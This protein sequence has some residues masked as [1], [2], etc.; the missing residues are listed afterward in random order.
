MK[1]PNCG[2]PAKE[3]VKVC[4]S[5]GEAYSSQDLLELCQ[6]EFMLQETESWDIPQKLRMP[7]IK[8]LETLR[9]RLQRHSPILPEEE[10]EVSASEKRAISPQ[11]A[12]SSHPTSPPKRIPFEQWLLS[13]ANIKLALWSGGLLL[14]LASIIFIGVKW[15]YI[16][17]PGK[18][19]ITL[20][21]T[22]LMYLGG[23]LL[24][25]R[26]AYR[27]GAIA[28]LGL[29][30]MFTPITFAVLQIYILGPSGLHNDVMWLIA[31][32]FCL[33]LYML[34]AYWT[35]S[36]LFTYISLAALSSAVTATL[37][38]IVAPLHAFILAYSLLALATQILAW[39]LQT[40]RLS[41]F[42]RLPLLIISQV[43][44]ALVIA[45]S[46]IGWILENGYTY[47]NM[48]SLWF[49][50][51]SLGVGVI[52]YV[53]ANVAFK[54]PIMRWLA[55]VLFPATFSLTLSEL[56]FSDSAIGIA[57]M[58][59][60]LAYLGVG[61]ALEKHEGRRAS[62]WPLYATAYIIAVFVTVHAAPDIT[63]LIQVLLG[64]VALLAVS[65][66]I[67]RN[68]W[69]AYGAVWLFILPFYLITS[70]HVPALY[71]R[72]LLMG[73][74]GLNYT[75]A[76]YVLSRRKLLLG[77]PFLTAAVYLSV[78]AVALTW[79]NPI[80][81]SLVLVSFAV[82]YILSSLWIG[83][84]WLLLP[85]LLAVN[86]AIL[87]INN[88]FFEDTLTREHSLIISYALLGITL[89]L[90]GRGLRR[91]K[92]EHWT[93]PLY[94]TGSIDLGWAYLASLFIGEWMAI[95]SS[96]TLAFLLLAF[97][98]LERAFFAEE[99]IPPLL[100][101]LGIGVIFTGAFFVID[102]ASGGRTM[103]IWPGYTAGLCT[104][105]VLTAGLLHREPLATIY[106][107]PLR[108]AGLILLAIP[109]AGSLIVFKP[110]IAALTFAFAGMTYIAYAISRRIIYLA[111]LGIGAFLV[112]IWAMLME[113]DVSEPQAY[114]IPLSLVLL[115]IG[116]NE[117]RRGKKAAY[118]LAT[119]LGLAVSMFSALIQSLPA[120][121]Y[122]YAI[123]LG[124]E[125]LAA[126]LW[127]IRY[128]LRSFVQLGGL[129]LIA[130][131]IIQFGP[132]FIE[133]PRWVQLGTTG[134]ILFGSGMAALFKREQIISVHQALK[135]EWR[136]FNP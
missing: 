69:W 78:I 100:A 132:A 127:G 41:N 90:C 17:G 29:A 71:N 118:I 96:V 45:A 32:S 15:A 106:S 31:S 48:G 67:H 109:M 125:S 81:A 46:F 55:A 112:V 103:D 23:Y 72:G 6:L 63:N 80:I 52:F 77:S 84:S 102:V 134:I 43:G 76:G 11:P 12:P 104:L 40:T 44:M 8:R 1:C 115:S 24:F 91:I 123:L 54:W 56:H 70:L 49:C 16:S 85:A 36:D 107:T 34:T 87:C 19:A 4:P 86:L 94:L 37:V 68:I 53:T 74:L 116:W 121:A 28:L 92:K 135:E 59:L 57:L 111:Y 62:G 64:D 21:A 130:N 73:L 14:V 101:Y 97:A 13:E 33:P 117:R 136:Q 122:E 83:W 50:L 89:S 120:G 3:Q 133:L 131:G 10:E 82:L 20:M 27:I 105:F 79:Y 39:T 9:T 129:A 18:F 128:R 61:Y 98:W 124:V 108:Y 110:I 5:C 119:L 60:A 88:V 7:F 26:P 66:A 47:N 35:Q 38:V 25:Q 126:V 51:S 114:I 99:K 75:A 22:G 42:T 58:V 2:A 93:W 95:G 30:S 113:F 65:T